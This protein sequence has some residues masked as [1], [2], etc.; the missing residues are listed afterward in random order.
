MVLIGVH[1][2]SE[3]LARRLRL[4][5]APFGSNRSVCVDA[6]TWPRKMGQLELV[7]SE[8]GGVGADP[9]LCFLED[10]A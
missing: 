4:H 7:W 8:D 10:S 9:A 6:R 5:L 2:Q 1:C 3:V